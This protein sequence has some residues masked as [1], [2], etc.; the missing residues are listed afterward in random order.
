[1]RSARS[2]CWRGWP[3]RYRSAS[4][5]ATVIS[6]GPE[7]SLMIS[8]SGLDLA[9]LEHPELETG[10]AMRD[11]QRRDARVVHADPDAV[12]GDPGLCDFE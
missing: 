11:E 10:T 8:V 6:S 1:M 4:T 9:L 5:S 12:A 2:S 7:A 3:G